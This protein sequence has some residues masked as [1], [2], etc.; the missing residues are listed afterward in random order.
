MIS[1]HNNKRRSKISL[2]RSEDESM[3]THK[4]LD[5]LQQSF[6]KVIV[7]PTKNKSSDLM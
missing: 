4:S 5:S 6:S 2:E 7:E 1:S 3:D